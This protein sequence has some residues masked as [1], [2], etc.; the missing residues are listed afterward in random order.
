MSMQTALD[1][2]LRPMSLDDL[3]QIAPW[4][5]NLDDVALFDRHM[6]MPVNKDAV[7]ESWQKALSHADPPSA[8]WF[9]AHTREGEPLGIGGLQSV[10]YIHGDAV[11]PMFVARPV[12]RRGLAR[13]ISARMMDL[14]FSHLRLHRLTTFFRA[15]NEA[16]RRTL[17]KA[18]WQVEGVLREAWFVDGARRDIMQVGILRDEWLAG[19]EAVYADLAAHAT[20]R[21][22]YHGDPEDD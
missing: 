4:F 14:A 22:R 21:L 9:I 13:S 8:Y 2:T 6:P 15:D 12:R 20:V 11:L 5:W 1:V 16:S 18:G 17:L 10:N 3:E 7:R 19:R